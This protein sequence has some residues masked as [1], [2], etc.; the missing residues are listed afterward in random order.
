MP[1]PCSCRR[2]AGQPPVALFKPAGVPACR[3]AEVVLP[4]DGYEAMR[5]ADLDGL[6][7]EQA[8][9]RMGVSRATFGRILEAAHRA[10]AEAL[11]HGHAL[12]I[13]GGPVDV[14]PRG[15]CC[16]G[17]HPGAGQHTLRGGC[18]RHPHQEDT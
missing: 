8:A 2:V 12:R 13:E 16:H 11:T 9:E 14:E 18:R 10:V 7:Q 3:M 5:L 4:L 17:R 15:R 6:Y 1:R